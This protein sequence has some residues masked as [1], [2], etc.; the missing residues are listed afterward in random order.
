MRVPPAEEA[1]A[2]DSVAG[3]EVTL[4]EQLLLIAYDGVTGRSAAG[5]QIALDCGVAG[6]VLAELALA[7]RIVVVDGKVNV[8]DPSSVGDP[9]FDEVLGRIV[10]EQKQRKPDWWVARTRWGIRNK[11]LARLTDRGVLQRQRHAVLRVFSVRRYPAIDS[12]VASNIR[13]R[14]ELVVVHRGSPDPRTDTLAALLNACGLARRTFPEVDRKQLKIRMG[15]LGEG[16]WTADAVRQA[17]RSIQS[18]D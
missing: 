6:G 8:V 3:V 7:G 12:G 18:S 5:G 13:S 11:M 15:E 16:Q 17:I 4:P 10:G 2:V 14:L 1:A 9:L